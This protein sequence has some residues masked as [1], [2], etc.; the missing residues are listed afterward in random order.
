M[1]VIF[2]HDLAL[3]PTTLQVERR[4]CGVNFAENERRA[5][6]G[7]LTKR[8]KSYAS[9]ESCQ[10][11]VYGLADKPSEKAKFGPILT[12]FVLRLDVQLKHTPF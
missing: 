4:P 1:A 9:S 12:R 7:R 11:E 2:T 10:L 3:A 6:W 5:F 8:K